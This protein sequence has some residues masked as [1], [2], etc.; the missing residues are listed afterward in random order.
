M[1]PIPSESQSCARSVLRA[2][3][4]ADAGAASNPP[5]HA[6]DRY[7]AMTNLPANPT[8]ARRRA[9]LTRS[10]SN[11]RARHVQEV[12]RGNTRAF[13]HGVFA[14][15]ANQADVQTEMSLIF[16]V[17]PLLDPIA[18]WSLV[19]LLASTNVQ[20]HRCLIAMQEGGLTS[21]LTAYDSRLS[22]LVERLERAVHERE[23]ERLIAS[24]ERPVDLSAYARTDTP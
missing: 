21:Q 14:I 15:V 5:N 20:R 9:S 19:E 11:R 16:A 12:L 3:H 24:R 22:A 23:R 1:L 2:V 6:F 17:R 13:L 4:R 18:D 8:P 7:S 10:A